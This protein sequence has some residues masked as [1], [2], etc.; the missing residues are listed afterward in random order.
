[1]SPPPHRHL[2]PFCFAVVQPLSC[3]RLFVTPWTAAHQAFLSS[4]ISQSLLKLTSIE[5]VMP[6]IQP[7]HPLSPLL[8]LLSIFPSIRVF[9]NVSALHIRWP[10]IGAS[11]S[12]LV[13]SSFFPISA[14]GHFFR[15]DFPDQLPN[16]SLELFYSYKFIKCFTRRNSAF[17]A[18]FLAT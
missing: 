10:N 17:P 9:S 5:S 3:V 16:P 6:S 18:R 7:S 11:A 15:E 1:M 14:Q 4:I 12:A 13:Y 2:I 8:F